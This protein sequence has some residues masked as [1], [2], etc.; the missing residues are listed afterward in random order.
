MYVM[1]ILSSLKTTKECSFLFVSFISL[2]QNRPCVFCL[3]FLF[4][5]FFQ[6]SPVGS[7]NVFNI[8]LFI[9]LFFKLIDMILFVSFILLFENDTCWFLIC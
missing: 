8:F 3:L 6:N 4:C 7:F 5:L 9:H 1:F 2:F